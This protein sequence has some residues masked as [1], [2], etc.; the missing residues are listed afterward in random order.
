[1]PDAAF[2]HPRLAALYDVL[3]D[4]RSDLDA[5][6]AIARELGARAVVDVGCGTGTFALLLAADGLS[7]TAVDPARASVDVARA[8]SGAERVCWLDG[9]ASAL[10]ALGADLAT[11]T[12]NVAQAIAD[13][14]DWLRA[15]RGI[16]GALA[17]DGRLVFET[18][19]PSARG[20]E[21]WTP[22]RTHRV[23]DVQ[24]IGR[25][26]TWTELTE[27]SL[28]LV[29]FRAT[30]VF[31]ADGEVLTSDS[32]LR[33]RDRREVEEQ[34]AEAGYAVEE[35]REAPDRPGRE[36]VFFAR[37]AAPGN[38]RVHDPKPSRSRDASVTFATGL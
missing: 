23:L 34:L 20:W 18:R 25:V 35:V 8:K 28:P 38:G 4:D 22:D 31:H 21:E 13:P 29:S 3:D 12:G 1:V 14:G 9:D 32:T 33:F 15:L 11:M 36:H 7:V 26:E 2:E 17:P 5:Y 16:H 10:P 30:F 37:R 6:V 19:V 24:G 27:V